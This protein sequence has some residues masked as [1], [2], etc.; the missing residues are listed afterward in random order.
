VN[1][2]EQPQRALTAEE[3]GPLHLI[4]IFSAD[5]RQFLTSSDA[6]GIMTAVWKVSPVASRWAVGRY[7]IMPDH[8]HFFARPQA[9][10]KPL[11]E[12]I[13]DWKTWTT[14]LLTDVVRI[15]PPIWQPEFFAEE[16]L[17]PGTYA[18][19]WEYVCAN[20]V[21]SG[22]APNAEAWPHSGEIE[23]LGF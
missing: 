5:R 7:L 3:E 22:H 11:D 2:L 17:S 15:E 10:G 6:V 18:E 19:K 20:P 23:K 8:V 9:M 21:R 4:T 16:L 12:F 14:R 13:R 1:T